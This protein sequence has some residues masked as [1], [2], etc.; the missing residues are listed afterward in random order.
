MQQHLHGS[1]RT[2]PVGLFVAAD[3]KLTQR[4]VHLHENITE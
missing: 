3:G 4:E 2:F 1:A